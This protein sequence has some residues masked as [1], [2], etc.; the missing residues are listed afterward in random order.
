MQLWNHSL[1]A[2]EHN[3]QE[4]AVILFFFLPCFY[5]INLYTKYINKISSTVDAQVY[6]TFYFADRK[7]LFILVSEYSRCG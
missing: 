3:H 5:L 6:C 4:A 1:K 2:G 7:Q